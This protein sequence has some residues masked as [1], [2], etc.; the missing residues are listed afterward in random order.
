MH[1]H[2][3][4]AE[5]A[6]P[7]LDDELSAP[8][9]FVSRMR[10]TCAHVLAQAVLELFPDAKLGIGPVIENGFYYDFQ[11][12]RPVTPDDLPA[13]EERMQRIVKDNLRMTRT[14]L[15]R[16]EAR[17]RCE[18]GGQP[19]KVALIDD[20]PEG[21]E[22]SFYSQGKEGEEPQF[23]DLCR[24]PHIES[25]G[26]IGAFKLMNVAGAYW[27][28]N[29][30][31]PQLTRIY[32][33]AFQKK[34]Q[35]EE[36]LERIEEAKRRDHKVLGKQLGIFM[37]SSLIGPGLPVWL[38]NGAAI[39]MALERYIQDQEK[40]AGY[41]HVFTPDLAHRQLYVTSGHWDHYKDGM[42]PVMKIDNEEFVL[43]P[44][45]CPHHIQVYKNE[46]RS[47]RDLPVRLAELGTMYRFEKSGELSGLSRV[48]AMTLSDAHIFCREDQ[49]KEEVKKSILLIEESYRRLGVT[50]YRYR[51]S[52]HD[53]ADDEKY[54]KD[55]AL[56]EK[57]E[58]EL[59]EVFEELGLPYFEGVG[60]AAFYGPKID[61]QLKNVL[62]REET[63]STVQV[64][65]HLPKQ[66]DLEYIGDDSRPHRPVMIHRGYLSTMERMIS[67]LIEHYAGAF[68]TWLAAEQVRLLPIADRHTP[69]CEELKQRMLRLGFR[70]A[71]DARS[72]KTNRKVAEAQIAK[73]PYMLVV[74]DRDI[75]NG[76][77][78]VRE[79]SRGDLGPRPVEEFLAALKNEVDTF[80]A[81]T[82]AGDVPVPAATK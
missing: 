12:P 6:Q 73:V 53:P 30:K 39:R 80:G 65:R 27:R 34:S 48:R 40:L 41:D 67:F 20:L 63:V 61:I 31:N 76:T 49:V 36:H 54:V 59:R 17:A 72:E 4:A 66:F 9:D 44:M 77:V 52:L 60:E 78:S 75:Q 56:W 68:P 22:I 69:W 11:F 57:A 70:A 43:R 58:G 18:A 74:G 47:Y 7:A 14:V 64:D 38:P 82:V 35:L 26:R 16:E 23:T 33:A 29:E 24:G 51:L 46:M 19:F 45:N 8:S 32:G 81:E 13:I 79:R 5:A 2:D 71:V 21:E 3:E 15:P 1:E 42:F 62:G 25:T 10:H 28:G 37:N 50:E 55:P